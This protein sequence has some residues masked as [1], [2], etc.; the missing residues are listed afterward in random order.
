MMRAYRAGIV[1]LNT[2]ILLATCHNPAA[3]GALSRKADYVTYID[4]ILS[5]RDFATRYA[6]DGA[7]DATVLFPSDN[8][9]RDPI[10]ALVRIGPK[11]VPLLIDCLADGR[12]TSV[13]FG[14]STVSKAMNVPLGYV[15]LDI[16]IGTIKAVPVHVA[17]CADDGLGACV[18]SGFYFRPDDYS[19]CWPDHCLA[20]P[21]VGVVQQN[22]KR[23]FLQNRIQ[24]VNPY[25][26]P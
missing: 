14:G 17:D 20:R 6:E 8:K 19:R 7:A 18:N 4:S 16:L 5:V 1:S 10:L 12:T 25:P 22:W 24:F 2:L 9:P 13:R 3:Q 11:S 15:C 26:R 21:W 23:L